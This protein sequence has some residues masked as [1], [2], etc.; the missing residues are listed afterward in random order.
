MIKY[1]KHSMTKKDKI[2]RLYEKGVSSTEIGRKLGVDASQVRMWLRRY[3][4]MGRTGLFHKTYTRID[5]RLREKIVSEVRHIKM[6][7][8]AVAMKYDVSRSSVYRLVR[9]ASAATTE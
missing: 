6:S 4:I 7:C 1:N 5:D 8:E 9:E 2:V 3:R